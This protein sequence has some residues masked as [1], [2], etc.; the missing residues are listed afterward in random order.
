[1][2]VGHKFTSHSLVQGIRRDILTIST[3]INISLETGCVQVVI[4]ILL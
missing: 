2:A 1:M 3:T 4:I